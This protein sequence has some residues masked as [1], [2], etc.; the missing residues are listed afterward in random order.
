MTDEVP[1]EKHYFLKGKYTGKSYE[2]V[3]TLYPDYFLF[4][5]NQPAYKVVDYFDFITYCMD[6]LS[7][8]EF[9]E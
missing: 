1:I 9:K 3:R 5:V 7:A 6:F 8:K 4:I 2:E